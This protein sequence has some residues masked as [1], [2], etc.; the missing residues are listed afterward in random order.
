MDG[1]LA[2]LLL[3]T[4]NASVSFLLQEDNHLNVSGIFRAVPEPSVI[5]DV[6]R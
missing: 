4:E 6:R 5:H 3:N 1:L 2:W